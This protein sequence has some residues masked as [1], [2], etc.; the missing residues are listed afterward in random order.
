M[1]TIRN[2]ASFIHKAG[3]M[4]NCPRY[5]NPIVMPAASDGNP[6]RHSLLNLVAEEDIPELL[7]AMAE[8]HHFVFDDCTEMP[9]TSGII[10]TPAKRLERKKQRNVDR[11]CFVEKPPEVFAYL[12]EDTANEEGEWSSGVPITYDEYKTIV[13]ASQQEQAQ[14]HLELAKFR[15]VMDQKYAQSLEVETQRSPDP[16]SAVTSTFSYGE[17]N[18][19]SCGSPLQFKQ[20][21][22]GTSAI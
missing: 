21:D 2:R 3:I 1:K 22:M 18:P 4:I 20:T 12:D 10:H 15:M 16:D 14:Q 6:V 8:E 13:E 9:T 11:I 7:Q 5:R 19:T 17:K